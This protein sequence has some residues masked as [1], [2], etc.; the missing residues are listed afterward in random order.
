MSMSGKITPK[1]SRN[2]G[3]EATVDD[4]QA[5]ERGDAPLS[6]TGHLN[7]LRSRLMTV[8]IAVCL[9][10]AIPF[11]IAGDKVLKLFTWPFYK[12]GLKNPNLYVFNFTEGFML[13]LK[14]CLVAGLLIVFPFIV[15][16]IWAYVRPA[17]DKDKRGFFRVII[18]C[19]IILFY[20]GATVTFFFLMPF[21]IRCW[22]ILHRTT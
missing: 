15:Y 22:P 3:R 9:T 13:Q 20:T 10:T 18:I 7:E 12:A 8:L 14:A 11:F 2:T 19:S 21:A 4:I 1:K 16:Q 17:I 6:I 5:L